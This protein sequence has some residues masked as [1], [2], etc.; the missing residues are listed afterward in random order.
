MYLGIE[1]GGTKLQ[2][3]IGP[4]SGAELVVLRRTDIDPSQG[5][6]GIRQQIETLAG[7]LIEQ[8]SPVAAGIGFGGPVEVAKGL[9][10]KS[11]HVDGWN[12]FDLAGW[13]RDTLGLPAILGNDAD[14]AGLAE[15]KFGA[16]RNAN[17]VLYV[18][19]GTGIGGGLIVDG[20]IF[21]G[22]GHATAEIG[23]MRPGIAAQ[24]PNDTIESHA[25][26]WGI[27][28]TAR[29][30]IEDT[31]ASDAAALLLACD[32]NLSQLTTKHVGKAAAG[33]NDLAQRVLDQAWQH[34]GWALA[35]VIT[36][37]SP[38]RIV[39]GGG[40]SLLGP[41][42]LFEPL[43]EQVARYVFP[44]LAGSYDIRPAQLG[45]EMVLY[46]AL[47]L[48]ATAHREGQGITTS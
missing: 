45:E 47:A 20:R 40:V 2:V 34:L 4:G 32:G 22:H 39:I 48:A 9:T 42:L 30:M 43:A 28:A 36:L 8:F 41:Q 33:G 6:V 14:V 23:H 1:I 29:R 44:P 13:C 5:A 7:E 17:P 3:A 10:I 18:T 38:E 24:W 27:A 21:Q 35:Q 16:G 37:V 26:G 46:G 11:H 31:N 12:C 19:I 25:S 15:A